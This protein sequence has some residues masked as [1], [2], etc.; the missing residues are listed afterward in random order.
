VSRRVGLFERAA[1]DLAFGSFRVHYAAGLEPRLEEYRLRYD[2]FVEEHHWESADA[3]RD[4]LERDEFDRFSCS[5]L[6]LDSVTGEAAACQRLILPEHLPN[7]RRTNAEREYRPMPSGPVVDF[8]TMPRSTWAEASRLTIAPAYR[9]GSARTSTPAMAAVSYASLALAIALDRT[10]VFTISDPRTARLTRRMG[11]PMHQVGQL[12]DFHGA[13]AV[14]RIE[15]AEV[16]SSVPSAWRP[17]VARLIDHARQVASNGT[18]DD[19]MSLH[20]A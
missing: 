13:R 1:D 6:L 15:L 9:W 18:I 16:W 10:V 8:S 19:R 20:A 4:R 17:F 7:G 12:V 3:C 2:A 5:V 11:F 14:F